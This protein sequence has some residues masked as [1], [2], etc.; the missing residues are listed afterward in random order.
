MSAGQR[1]VLVRDRATHLEAMLR[2]A[3]HGRT[4]DM[5][6]HAHVLA[7]EWRQRLAL[8]PDPEVRHAAAELMDSMLALGQCL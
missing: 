6:A 2:H 8:H 5:L 1:L 7:A 3:R 4:A